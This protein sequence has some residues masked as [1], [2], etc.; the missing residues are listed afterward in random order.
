MLLK[1]IPHPIAKGLGTLLGF[2]LLEDLLAPK[3]VSAFKNFMPR[4]WGGSANAMPLN[5]DTLPN[6]PIN[7]SSVSN[8][9]NTPITNNITV[10]INGAQS[11]ADIVDELNARLNN[12]N[13]L[14]IIR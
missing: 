11:P 10:N 7:N 6:T 9:N 4:D 2:V 12:A 3:D 14:S 13:Q 1:T 5:M 8:H